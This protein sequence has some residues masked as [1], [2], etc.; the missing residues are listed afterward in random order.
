MSKQHAQTC[1]AYGNYQPPYEDCDCGAEANG[2]AESPF[3]THECLKKGY[4]PWVDPPCPQCEKQG[5][6]RLPVDEAK[7]LYA[8]GI[9]IGQ[10]LA[11]A[12]IE[13]LT[14]SIQQLRSYVQHKDG[15]ELLTAP[16]DDWLKK[17]T[18]KLDDV[19]KAIGGK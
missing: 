16:S 11:T 2:T 5:A 9:Q 10:Q 15:C 17:C 13:A 14:E 4:T 18:C 3:D 7:H 6:A 12:K 19:L 8:E 1:P